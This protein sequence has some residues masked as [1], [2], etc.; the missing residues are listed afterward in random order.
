YLRWIER[1]ETAFFFSAYSRSVSEGNA[2]FQKLLAER[3]IDFATAMPGK[4]SPGSVTFL[5]TGEEVLHN[6][7]VTKAWVEDPLKD[8]LA[9][10][11]GFPRT[12]P[13]K[14]MQRR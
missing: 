5:D 11:Q 2:A 14:P 9:K 12:P 7:F 1:R 10:I 4:L 3:N 6:D 13:P 8:V